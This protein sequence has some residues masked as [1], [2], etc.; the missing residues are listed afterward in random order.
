MP[1]MISTRIFPENIKTTWIIHAPGR[2]EIEGEDSFRNMIFL[3]KKMQ[4]SITLII[5]PIHVQVRSDPLIEL[6]VIIILNLMD[7]Q[8]TARSASSVFRLAR[9]GES[10]GGRLERTGDV[11]MCGEAE[12]RRG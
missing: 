4:N 6:V 2:I 1:G 5:H 12:G 9:F 7:A 8:E 11:R 10:R 3:N